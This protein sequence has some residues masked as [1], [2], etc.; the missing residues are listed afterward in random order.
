MI[1]QKSVGRDW[2]M[3]IAVAYV[4]GRISKLN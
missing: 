1:G 3:N 2:L 4:Q